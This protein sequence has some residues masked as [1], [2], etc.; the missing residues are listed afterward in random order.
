MHRL[1]TGTYLL[2]PNRSKFN[3]YEVDPSCPLCNAPEETREHILVNCQA[4]KQ[5]REEAITRMYPYLKGDCHDLTDGEWTQLFLDCSML[6]KLNLDKESEN[7]IYYHARVMAS[8]IA[9]RRLQLL[10]D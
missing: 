10:Q 9:R 3:Q 8:K 2:N 1:Q 5:D 7:Q 4:Y 6:T